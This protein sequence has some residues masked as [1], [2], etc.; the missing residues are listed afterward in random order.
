MSKEQN[1]YPLRR[2]IPLTVL[3]LAVAAGGAAYLAA[4][5]VR[6]RLRR[7]DGQEARDE[8]ARGA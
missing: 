1:P 4:L 7:R 8:E 6:E 3:T 5:A 2:M